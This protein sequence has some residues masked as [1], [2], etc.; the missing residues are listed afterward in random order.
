M[1]A[2]LLPLTTEEVWR[3]LTGER[4]VHLTDWPDAAALPADDALVAAMDE[5]RDVASAGL[6]LRKAHGL[7]TRLPLASLTLVVDDAS[8]LAGFEPI[9]ADEL[10]VKE[11]R[12][13]QAG[14][15]EAAAYA[16]E[17]RLTVNA[18][19]AG[20]RL[21][22]DVQTVIKGSKAGD[23]SV[24]EDGT[25][26][27]AG[28]ELAEGEFTLETV[29]GEGDAARGDGGA[30]AGR[31]RRA[32]HRH[33]P[34]ARGRGRG[35]RPGPDRCSRPA[36]TPASTSRTGSRSRWSGPADVLAAARTHEELLARE[37]LATRWPT[38][39]R[40]RR[41]AGRSE[42]ESPERISPERAG[43]P[44]DGGPHPSGTR[45]SSS[46]SGRTP[47][48]TLTAENATRPATYAVTAKIWASPKPASRSAWTSWAGGAVRV[49]C[50]RARPP[51]QGLLG[52]VEP[53][54]VAGQH[55]GRRLVADLAGQPGTPRQGAVRVAQG[56][57]HGADQDRPSG[58][59]SGRR[60]TSSAPSRATIPSCAAGACAH[61]RVRFIT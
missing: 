56:R 6:A 8:A 21:G 19:A 52:R 37:T 4:S 40:R 57:G 17:Q 58:G 55:A 24:A 11:V 14:S 27:C 35:P 20:P 13:V 23:W 39:R 33:H 54:V 18:R 42:L 30:A 26:T 53:G 49:A 22:R 3:G 10:N 59:T 7:R 47:S 25:V 51:G 45:A 16:V 34:R 61:S 12:L 32:R 46:T 60:P 48:A 50:D 1:A 31:L 5:V 29:A 43:D 36:A 2:P 44:V 28:F 41:R 9:L 15:E 38:R